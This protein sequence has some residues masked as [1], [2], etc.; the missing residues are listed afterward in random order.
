[1]FER[2]LLFVY[3]NRKNYSIALLTHLCKQN[4]QIFQVLASR[5]SQCY[6][7]NHIQLVPRRLDI[8]CRVIRIS[9]VILPQP[10][11]I[12]KKNRNR[13]INI[14][15]NRIISSQFAKHVST[16]IISNVRE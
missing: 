8:G 2:L 4:L 15:L 12:N 11:F 16:H 5:V 6:E 3:K 13:K 14:I 7:T 9:F 1:M 10:I